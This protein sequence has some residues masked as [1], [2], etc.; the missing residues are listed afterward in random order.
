MAVLALQLHLFGFC[1][2]SCGCLPVCMCVCL[3]CF[4]KFNF[5]L[6]FIFGGAGSLLLHRLFSSCGKQGL[7]SSFGV[8]ASRCR[9]LECSDSVIM[10]TGSVAL[11]DLPRSGIKPVSPALVGR[12]FT[13]EPPGK[14]SLFLKICF[15][16]CCIACRIL[17]PQPGMEPM[18][19]AMEAQDLN[20]WTARKVPRFRISDEVP[21][22]VHT[23]GPQAAL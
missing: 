5:S 19:P 22:G 13:T 20:H 17:V 16:S 7:L 8:W 14:F 21:D 15:W 6:L 3:L 11:W 2:L 10:G 23:S 9:A 1:L 12:F 4:F 18:P